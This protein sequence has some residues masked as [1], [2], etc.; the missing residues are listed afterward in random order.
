MKSYIRN[1]CARLN[2]RKIAKVSAAVAFGVVLA[3]VVSD[4]NAQ[5]TTMSFPIVDDILCAFFTY[6]RNKLVPIIGGIVAVVSVGGHFLGLSKVW[7]VLL[8][9]GIGIGLVMAIG[10]LI[11]S[12]SGGSASCLL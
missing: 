8:N 11:A 5:T 1:I 2:H 9:I 7:G 12:Y 6:A 3:S 10:G 4:A